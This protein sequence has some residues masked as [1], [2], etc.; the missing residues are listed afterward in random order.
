[1]E[2]T[3]PSTGASKVTVVQ[4][5]R[6]PD[7]SSA[8]LAGREQVRRAVGATTRKLFEEAHELADELERLPPMPEAVARFIAA[9]KAKLTEVSGD[10]ETE[11]RAMSAHQLAEMHAAMDAICGAPEVD[12]ED[13]FIGDLVAF[14]VRR[15]ELGFDPDGAA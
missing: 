3:Q 7:R 9:A 1:M 5:P 10:I 15:R 12:L 4:F 2:E 13:D 14:E 6:T 11:L 8:T